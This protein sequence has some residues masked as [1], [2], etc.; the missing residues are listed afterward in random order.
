MFPR[1]LRRGGPVNVRHRLVQDEIARLFSEL[2]PASRRG[3]ARVLPILPDATVG[4][5]L[6]QGA[7]FTLH[8]PER[9]SAGAE[10]EKRAYVKFRIPAEAKSHIQRELRRAGISWA[11]LFPDLENL[12]REIRARHDLI[13]SDGSWVS[14]VKGGGPW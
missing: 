7:C 3:E 2:P 4:R 13:P 8:P 11:T 5:M 1:R 12:A 14:L 10:I 9:K 6:Q